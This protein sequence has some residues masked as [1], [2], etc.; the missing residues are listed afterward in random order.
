MLTMKELQYVDL[1]ANKTP[2]PGYDYSLDILKKMKK[3]YELY[4]EK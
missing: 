1:W 3:C 2:M 4:N